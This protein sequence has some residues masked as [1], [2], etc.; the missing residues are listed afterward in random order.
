MAWWFGAVATVDSLS[1]I[2]ILSFSHSNSLSQIGC[3]F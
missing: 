1:L 3:G 2:L